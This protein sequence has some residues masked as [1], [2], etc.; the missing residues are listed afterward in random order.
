MI[1]NVSLVEG[2][3]GGESLPS[4]VL[5]PRAVQAVEN[6]QPDLAIAKQPGGTQAPAEIKA[7]EQPQD[8]KPQPQ[9][10]KAPPAEEIKKPQAEEVKS[11]PQPE[12]KPDPK[13]E[14]KPAARTQTPQEAL[15]ELKRQAQ[16]KESAQN[17]KALA[18]ALS[19][20][21]YDVTNREEGEIS[22]GGGSGGGGGGSGGGGIAGG[23]PGGV[24]GGGGTGSGPGGGGLGGLEV[25]YVGHV[26]DIVKKHWS[27]HGD[28]RKPLM[29]AV[30]IRTDANGKVIPIDLEQRS[31]DARFDASVM[32]IFEHVTVL[33]EPPTPTLQNII[34]YFNSQELRG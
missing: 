10:I 22:S 28:D 1:Y 6:P 34:L 19:G 20:V 2:A 5:G 32:N 16:R 30:R 3:P 9:E 18:D 15:D 12:P 23:G 11:E 8:I 29:A 25:L 14:P 17:Q 13:P 7:L 31:G 24:G 26:S 33:P 21:E 4:P 27:W